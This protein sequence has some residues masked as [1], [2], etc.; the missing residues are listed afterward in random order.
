[1]MW[2]WVAKRIDGP[3]GLR[4][5]FGRPVTIEERSATAWASDIV[6]SVHV[7]LQLI[8]LPLKWHRPM[9][10]TTISCIDD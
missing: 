4:W 6:Q 7:N 5:S 8:A 10:Q 9:Q 1:M 2:E 3:S